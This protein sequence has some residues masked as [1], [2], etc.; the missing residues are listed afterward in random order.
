MPDRSFIPANEKKWFIPLFDVYVRLLFKRRFHKVYIEQTY[1]PGNRSTIYY[2]NHTSWWDGLIPLLL[3]QKIFKQKARAMMED[4]QMEQH[5]FFSRIGAFSV[6]LS[7]T[8]AVIK[9][10]RY[11]IE[12][13]KRENSSLFIFPE[14]EIRPFSYKQISFKSGLAWIASKSQQADIVPI[15]IYMHTANSD[16]PELF[17]KIGKKVDFDIDEESE[18]LNTLFELKMC[19][20]LKSL[21]QKA[22]SKK[23]Q[24]DILIR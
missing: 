1:R 14:G 11:A 5:R 21:Q 15:G 16:K 6:N 9:S 20:L 19:N 23:N 4:K 8:R 24:F 12:S 10:L 22:H 18:K 2:L 3:N 17:I 7:N 13:L